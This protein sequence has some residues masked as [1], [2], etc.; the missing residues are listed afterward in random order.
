ML[1]AFLPLGELW[2]NIAQAIA[3]EGGISCFCVS[4]S[5]F[6]RFPWDSDEKMC[7][8]PTEI[9]VANIQVGGDEV[10]RGKVYWLQK[11]VWKS[12]L[13]L[14]HGTRAHGYLCR[15]LPSW[16][17]ISFHLEFSF[18]VQGQRFYGAV[19]Y[20]YLWNIK[21][22]CVVFLFSSTVSFSISVLLMQ[23]VAAPGEQ[24]IYRSI[25]LL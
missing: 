21:W 6:S 8:L 2:T 22:K 9:Q 14:S 7:V 18:M 25:A 10:W 1:L 12:F 11:S 13:I 3:S 24:Q 20:F 15:I 16:E 4:V 19:D 5:A 17:I 23:R